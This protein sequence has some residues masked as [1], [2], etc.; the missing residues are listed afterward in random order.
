MFDKLEIN[1]PVGLRA[2]KYLQKIIIK[3]GLKDINLPSLV[4]GLNS[5]FE[6]SLAENYKDWDEALRFCNSCQS[7]EHTKELY[8]EVWTRLGISLAIV[9]KGGVIVGRCLVNVETNKMAQTYGEFHYILQARLKFA[10]F[11]EGELIAY[12]EIQE[13]MQERQ[14]KKDSMGHEKRPK[15]KTYYYEETLRD[16]SEEYKRMLLDRKFWRSMYDY[17]NEVSQK[18]S[19]QRRY[20]KHIRK[21]GL[22][23]GDPVTVKVVTTRPI[24]DEW[25][26]FKE[27]TSVESSEIYLDSTRSFVQVVSNKK[28]SWY[29]KAI[30]TEFWWGA[31]TLLNE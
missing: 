3:E 18:I 11:S 16:N 1:V 8:H 17:D 28:A 12:E 31:L 19:A 4:E 15:S 5:V 26:Y 29:K 2:G 20:L 10:G 30:K 24:S 25:E 9:R 23:I 7:G 6:F 13:E 21:Q 27:S 14:D 22:K